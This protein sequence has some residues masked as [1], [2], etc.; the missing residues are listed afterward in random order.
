LSAT[1]KAL[2]KIGE[3]RH[4][5]RCAIGCLREYGGFAR[6]GENE[7]GF[8]LWES[9]GVTIPRL[10]TTRQFDSHPVAAAD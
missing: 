4:W 2:C 3:V 7:N 5:R 1:Y 10:L 8:C 9:Q 6:I